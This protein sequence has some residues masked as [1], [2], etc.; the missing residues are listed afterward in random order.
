M[1]LFI[2]INIK[3]YRIFVVEF[4]DLNNLM[5]K[6]IVISSHDDFDNF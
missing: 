5:I 1:S 3:L 2:V 4:F 6:F